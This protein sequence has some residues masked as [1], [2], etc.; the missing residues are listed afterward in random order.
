M[1]GCVAGSIGGSPLQVSGPAAGLTVVVGG[2][3]AEFGWSVTCAITVAARAVQVLLGLSG[4]ARAVLAISPVVVHAM[5]AGIGVTIALQ[6]VHVLLGGSSH[7]TA[8]HN[9]VKLPGQLLDADGDGAFRWE[10]GNLNVGNPTT[11]MAYGQTYHR[12]NWTITPDETGTRFVSD[13]T[14]HGM[15][16]SI[17][18]VSSF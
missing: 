15:F 18:N 1:G 11:T 8:W 10:L 9:L 3:I 13:R 17:E 14:G 4:V 5:L 2:L 7:S 6:Q 12:G 16:V